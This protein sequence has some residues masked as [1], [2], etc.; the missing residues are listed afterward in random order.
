MDNYSGWFTLMI[1]ENFV[2]KL[3]DLDSDFFNVKLFYGNLFLLAIGMSDLAGCWDLRKGSRGDI[4][5][6]YGIEGHDYVGYWTVEEFVKALKYKNVGYSYK[7]DK[8]L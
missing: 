4:I 6:C 2:E 1:D 8:G 5:V 7:L 3:L